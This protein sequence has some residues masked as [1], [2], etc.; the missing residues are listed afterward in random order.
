MCV[1]LFLSSIFIECLAVVAQ[2]IGPENFKPLANES[3][4]FGMRILKQSSDPDIKK[5]VY[6]LFAALSIVIKH[7]ISPVLPQVIKEMIESIQSTEGIIVL[8]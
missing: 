5:S 3:L 7:E 6:A 4:E 2:F 8:Y 1:L